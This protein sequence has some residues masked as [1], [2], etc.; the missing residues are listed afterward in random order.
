M[1]NIVCVNN[2]ARLVSPLIH[3]FG[4]SVIQKVLSEHLSARCWAV[5]DTC[6]SFYF[7]F[8]FLY[9]VSCFAVFPGSRSS[10]SVK[11]SFD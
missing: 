6:L 4:Q 7:L 2:M 9:F 8:P 3:M 1:L 5:Y 11:I 10:V